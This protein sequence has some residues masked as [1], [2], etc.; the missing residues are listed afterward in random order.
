M[1]DLQAFLKEFDWSKLA[2]IVLFALPGFISLRV[3]SLI[4]PTS[5]RPFKDEIGEVISFGVLNAMV[6]APLFALTSPKQ[7]I[8]LYI[9]AIFTLVALPALWPFLLRWIMQRLRDADLI[10]VGSRSAW[11]DVF[12]RQ[13]PYFVI[14]HLKDGAR[15]GGYYG[16]KSFAGLHPISGHLYLEELWYIDDDGKFLEKVPES[17]GLILRPDDYNYIEL[18]SPPT[19]P[20]GVDRKQA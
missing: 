8:V 14:V 11:D 19:E 20:E 1:E 6:C 17:R 13:E 9:L 4:V 12:L 7:P 2:I 3:W 10:L 16:S 5:E 18:L 15:A